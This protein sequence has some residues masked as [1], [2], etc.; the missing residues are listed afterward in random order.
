MNERLADSL[1]VGL[2]RR[3]FLILAAGFRASRTE[4]PLHVMSK[5]CLQCEWHVSDAMD[6]TEAEASRE[7]IEHFV[8]TGH[9]I[10]SL[11]LP[12]PVV[13]RN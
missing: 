5:Y 3:D 12:P 13:L 6:Y 7:A 9:S 10:D 4:S 8:E 11:R 2:G 1:L